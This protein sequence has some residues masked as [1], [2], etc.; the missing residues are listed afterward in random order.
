MLL[1]SAKQL[2]ADDGQRG[3]GRKKEKRSK[4]QMAW[5][6]AAA[7]GMYNETGVFKR[8]SCGFQFLAR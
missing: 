4:P 5:I 1:S 2:F 3:K 8:V 6:K 7:V